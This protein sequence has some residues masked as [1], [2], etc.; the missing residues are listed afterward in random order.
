MAFASIRAARFRSFLTMLGII[1]GVVGVIT[2]VSL[3]EGVKNQISGKSSDVNKD[4]ITVRPG[5]LVKRDDGGQVSG[6]NLLSFLTSSKISEKDLASVS[7]NSNVGTTVPLSVIPGVPVYANQS[8]KDGFVMATNE[9][10][11]AVVN[12]KVEFGDFFDGDDSN[13]RVAI[14]G[15]GV[16]E[17]LFKENNPIGKSFLI[18]GQQFV[19]G[20][21]FERFSVNPLSPTA[22]YNDG[23]F[24]PYNTGKAVL[25]E[26]LDFYE[27]L[28]QPKDASQNS[29]TITQINESLKANHA[30]QEDFT[31]LRQ[32]ELVDIAD[33]VIS[34]IT[35]AT[36]IIAT[37]ALFVGGVGI[38]N[39]MLVSVTERTREIGI[40]KAVGATNRQIQTQFLVE[41]IV[42]S[43]WGAAIGI[44]IS[45]AINALFRVL[46][47][48]GPVITWQ[49]V[50]LSAG[51]SIAIG[52]IFGMIPAVKASRKDPIEALR[53]N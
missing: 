35:T 39:V 40:R 28:V 51:V 43:T 19:V 2:I 14:I 50:V 42:I 5:S 48:I 24:I 36:T 49:I 45:G 33:R 10:F 17:N 46:T 31:V 52:V 53:S 1:I 21:V 11:P 18:R 37:I 38:M 13:R 15:A 27:I 34:V 6:I 20:G 29:Q 16:A 22:D 9:H 26:K 47:T 12:Q 3:G 41:A 23:I 8:F 32:S 7:Q 4:L 30:G 44:A 25:G